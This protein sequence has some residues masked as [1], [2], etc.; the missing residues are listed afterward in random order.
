MPHGR[1]G[2]W[3]SSLQRQAG[4]GGGHRVPNTAVCPSEGRRDSHLGKPPTCA[5]ILPDS[6]LMPQPQ[7]Q[8]DAGTPHS[9]VC[10]PHNRQKTKQTKRNSKNQR[11]CRRRK[12]TRANTIL[13]EQRCRPQ[14]QYGGGRPGQQRVA[15]GGDPQSPPAPSPPGPAPALRPRPESSGPHPSHQLTRWVLAPGREGGVA[16][17]RTGS[18]P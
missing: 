6:I 13:K 18:H 7:M 4:R 8:R 9:G 2:T 16:A 15:G 10:L 17:R 12:L 5:H 14:G 11:Q 1:P 3:E